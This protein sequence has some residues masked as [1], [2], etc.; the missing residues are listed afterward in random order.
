MT[1]VPVIIQSAAAAITSSINV[2]DCSTLLFKKKNIYWKPVTERYALSPSRSRPYGVVPRYL[3][4]SSSQ[5]Y[6]D[7][8]RDDM[9]I[10]GSYQ[11]WRC[12][13]LFKESGLCMKAKQLWHSQIKENGPFT[14]NVHVMVVSRELCGLCDS[15]CS[16]VHWSWCS[17]S[18]TLF[19]N[20]TR[21]LAAHVT[22]LH[23]SANIVVLVLLLLLVTGTT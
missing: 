18:E 16:L 19:H 23:P 13:W 1:S 22:L 17:S 6:E 4:R 8:N 15:K 9:I 7:P 14:G 12:C 2:P 20:T 21:R 3:F 10:W 5:R 11:D